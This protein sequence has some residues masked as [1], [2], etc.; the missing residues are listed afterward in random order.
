MDVIRRIS[1]RGLVAGA[2]FCALASSFP[3]PSKADE[4][5]S[6]PQAV[7]RF[8]D[9]DLSTPEGAEALYG[10]IRPAADGVCWRMYSSLTYRWSKSA[11][12]K[13][14]IGDAV[15]KVNRPLLSAVYAAKYGILQPVIVTAAQDR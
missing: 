4:L 13:S 7:V 9:L 2:A 3:T 10:R 11:C 15:T 5:S 1:L 6:G 8:A 14:V 12:L